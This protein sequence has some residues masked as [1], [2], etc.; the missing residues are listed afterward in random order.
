MKKLLGLISLILVA[1]VT[2]AQRPDGV[3][4]FPTDTTTNAETVN[5]ALASPTAITKNYA[6]TIALVP[7]NV[8]GTATVTAMP[9]GSLDGT[10]WYDLESSA[11]TVNNAGTVALTAFEYAD[12]NWKYY[13]VKLVSTGTGVSQFNGKLGLKKK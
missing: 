9:Q 10:S 12:A 2:M 1:V 6:V 4:D 3:V 5:Y 7:V 8:S 13:R 11:S